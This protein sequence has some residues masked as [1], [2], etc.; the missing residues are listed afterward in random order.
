VP[1]SQPHADAACNFFELILKHTQD[2]W[3]GKPFLLAPWQEE[4]VTR[5]FG[6]LD[7]SGNRIIQMLYE[8]VPK[9]AGKTEWAAGLALMVLVLSSEPGCQVYGAA[10]ATRQAMNFTAPPAKWSNR[11]SCCVSGS[12]FCAAP[13][14]S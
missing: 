14:G 8:E 12:A 1:F 6:L 4:A 9:K 13:T 5:V 11:V 2:E 7:N 3:Y 10:A